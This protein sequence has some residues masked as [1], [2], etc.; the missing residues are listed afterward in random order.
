VNK[1]LGISISSLNAGSIQLLIRKLIA[2]DNHIAGD[3]HNAGDPNAS[4]AKL[5]ALSHSRK[6]DSSKISLNAEIDGNGGPTLKGT[7]L[8]PY[9]NKNWSKN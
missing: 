1:W 7:F 4:I 9:D 8:A 2:K 3:K 5:C 6:V